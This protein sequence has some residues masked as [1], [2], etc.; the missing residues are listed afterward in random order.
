MRAPP[1]AVVYRFL[2]ECSILFVHT[3]G[4]QQCN[5]R[6]H[7][8]APTHGCRQRGAQ[9]HVRE[10]GFLDVG[11]SGVEYNEYNAYTMLGMIDDESVL[12]VSG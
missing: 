11:E 3:A 6:A 10:G 7:T 12:R 9:R 1:I 5:G 8:R 4:T 2:T